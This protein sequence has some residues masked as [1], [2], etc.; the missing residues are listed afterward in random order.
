MAKKRRGV[1]GL[2]VRRP[3]GAGNPGAV[4]YVPVE[5]E[6]VDWMM[7]VGFFIL[8]LAW[9]ILIARDLDGGGLS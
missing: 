4:L 7:L 2:V 6:K 8:G 1:G 9:G 3:S 5:V